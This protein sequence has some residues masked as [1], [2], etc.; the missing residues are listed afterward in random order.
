[1]HKY[2]TKEANAIIEYSIVIAIIVAAMAGIHH[3]L[4]RSIQARVKYEI[5]TISPYGKGA[6]LEWEE[7]TLSWRD[8]NTNYH[9][10]ENFGGNFTVSA[11]T[12]EQYTTLSLPMPPYVM[13]HKN[14][15]RDV[16]D[17][18]VSPP[19]IDM[20]DHKNESDDQPGQGFQR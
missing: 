7:N 8:S 20:P 16:Q 10:I 1:M 13:E 4:K 5:D 11:V 14:A 12:R 17:V 15:S 2:F 18:A 9:K 19:K 6:G 3:F